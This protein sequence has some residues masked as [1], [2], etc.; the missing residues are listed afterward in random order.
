MVVFVGGLNG[1]FNSAEGEGHDRTSLELLG[2][3]HELMV[4]THRAARAAGAS[5][6]VVLIG[7][8]VVANWAQANADAVLA[9]GYGGQEAG[10]SIWDVLLGD[11]MYPTNCSRIS[12]PYCP[13]TCFALT[14]FTDPCA[15]GEP[16][17]RHTTM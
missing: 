4:A 12:R 6:V 9:A 2:F 16:D 14:L 10:N 8:P 13:S 15:R 7:S 17:W 3:Q 11:C 5:F 1:T